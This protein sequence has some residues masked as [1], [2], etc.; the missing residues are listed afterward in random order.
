MAAFNAIVDLV[1]DIVPTE[2]LVAMQS[3]QKIG[4][5]EASGVFDPIQ[6]LPWHEDTVRAFEACAN[7]IA[8]PASQTKRAE[9]SL[10][11]VTYL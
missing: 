10:W 6:Q 7:E 8:H 4:R 11:I 3:L 5:G 1:K 9:P 2:V